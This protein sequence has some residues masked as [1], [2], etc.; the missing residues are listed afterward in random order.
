[1]KHAFSLALVVSSLLW[2]AIAKA[3][4]VR[5]LVAAGQ[6]QG[7][8]GVLPQ[9]PHLLRGDIHFLGQLRSAGFTTQVLTQLA[10]ERAHF[11]DHLG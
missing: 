1:M 7:L 9:L 4:P 6:G 11:V 5:I 8:P 10:L 3:D 2:T